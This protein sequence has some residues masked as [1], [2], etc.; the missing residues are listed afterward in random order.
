MRTFYFNIS[1]IFAFLGSITLGFAEGKKEKLGWE[2]ELRTTLNLA[3]GSFSNW[4]KGGENSITWI[5]FNGES[6]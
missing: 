6:C 1:L 2:N 4:A 3:E 5:G